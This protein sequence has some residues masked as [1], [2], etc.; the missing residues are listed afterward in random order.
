MYFH[1]D[2]LLNSLRNGGP[3]P[4]A[5]RTKHGQ[6]RAR[7]GAPPSQRVKNKEEN[8]DRFLEHFYAF[9]GLVGPVWATGIGRVGSVQVLKS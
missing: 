1:D 2:I 5:P 8:L 4:G 6:Y 7:P 3:R 9:A